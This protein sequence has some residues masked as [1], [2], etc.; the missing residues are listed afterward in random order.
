[1][2]RFV[3]NSSVGADPGSRNFYLRVKGETESHVAQ[4]G[5]ASLDIV[6]PSLLTGLRKDIRPFELA[7][8]ALAPV[9]NPFLMGKAQRYRAIAAAT[10]AAA[11]VSL[12]RSQRKGI[13]RHTHRE[14]VG[15]TTTPRRSGA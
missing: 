12:A 3:L 15:L 8:M 11:M 10:V 2:R 6:Q 1:M 4:I 7:G 9:L 5:F 13:A 14:M